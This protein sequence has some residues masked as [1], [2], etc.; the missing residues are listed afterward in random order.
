MLSKP[1]SSPPEM[2]STTL[3][4]RGLGRGS[5]G[6][7]ADRVRREQAA[8]EEERSADLLVGGD[9]HAREAPVPMAISAAA[10]EEARLAD[11]GLTLEGDRSQ[12]AR[13]LVDLLRDRRE[14]GCCDR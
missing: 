11:A 14:L 4:T 7:V 5:P 8:R 6:R 2:A 13:R 10:S 1:G 9:R 3:R 12:A